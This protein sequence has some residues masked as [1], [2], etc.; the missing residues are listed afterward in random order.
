MCVR[1]RREARVRC[2][3]RTEGVRAAGL[4]DWEDTGTQHVEVFVFFSPTRPGWRD[5]GILGS[6]SRPGT[7]F[8]R[9]IFREKKIFEFCAN[10]EIEDWIIPTQQLNFSSIFMIKLF[11]FILE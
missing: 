1:A 3:R 10:L 7:G 4:P 2:W 11:E 9:S 6:V 5:V 8:G